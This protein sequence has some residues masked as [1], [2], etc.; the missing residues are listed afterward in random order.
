MDR[1]VYIASATAARLETAQAVAANNLANA[2]TIGFKADLLA[3]RAA[4]LQGDGWGSR[5]YAPVTGAGLD[6][7]A[8][9]VTQTGRDLDLA[10]DGDG[11]MAV[12]A[13]DG[14]EAYTR[15]GNLRVSADGMLQTASG[16][17]VLGDGGPLLVPPYQSISI[18]HDGTVSVVPDGQG[19]AAQTVVGRIKLV[20]PAPGSLRKAGDGTLRPVN[21][22]T[23]PADAAVKVTPG[24]LEGSNVSTV[25]AMVQM[26]ET[27]R[28]YELQVR[29]MQAAEKADQASSRLLS[30][31]G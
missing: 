26:I 14:S 21:G 23:L 28:Q 24:A 25:G 17:A 5:V 16:Q 12:Q 10:I 9:A 27:S 4:L 19:P 20:K 15:A 8:G 30:L 29:L 22:G 3:S 31:N 18:G 2:S 6:A 11:A 1:L 13:T 7:S